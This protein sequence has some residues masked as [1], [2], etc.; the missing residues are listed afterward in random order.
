MF[1]GAGTIADVFEASSFQTWS[2]GTWGGEGA[3][4][5]PMVRPWMP[6]AGETQMLFQVKCVS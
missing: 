2:L 5:E 6:S 3:L 4:F 1:L